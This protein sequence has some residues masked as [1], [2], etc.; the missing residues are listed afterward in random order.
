VSIEDQVRAI[1]R[2]EVA[3]ALAELPRMQEEWLSAAEAAALGISP[4]WARTLGPSRRRSPSRLTVLSELTLATTAHT[5]R[6]PGS[7]SLGADGAF[8]SSAG[9]G[10]A[11]ARCI[12]SSSWSRREA[13]VGRVSTTPIVR[14]RS[15]PAGNPGGARRGSVS[16]PPGISVSDR[17]HL[18]PG[19]GQRGSDLRGAVEVLPVVLPE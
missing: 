3:T 5:R 13:I 15:E 6:L 16:C 19:V 9:A 11:L 8:H 2:D 17:G 10:V 14:L 7:R 18:E 4:G 12:R 1:V